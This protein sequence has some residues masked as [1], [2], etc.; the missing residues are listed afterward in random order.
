VTTRLARPRGH[1]IPAVHFVSRDGNVTQRQPTAAGPPSQRDPGWPVT[2]EKATR[3]TGTPLALTRT[4]APIA[5][6][7]P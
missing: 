1:T 3:F 6:T 5:R 4:A 7:A 2:Q